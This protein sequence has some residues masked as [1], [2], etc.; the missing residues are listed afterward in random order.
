MQLE[1]SRTS[2][3]AFALVKVGVRALNF[4]KL[5]TM[6]PNPPAS[7]DGS[8]LPPRHRPSMGNLAKD[9]TEQDLWAFDDIDPMAEEITES[10]PKSIEQKIPVPR[11]TEKIKVRQLTDPTPS[12]SSSYQD[13]VRVN[14]GKS[15]TMAHVE[16]TSG[17]SKPGREFD[18]LDHWDEPNAAVPIL[19]IPAETVAPTA[20]AAVSPPPPELD[21]EFSP[22]VREQAAPVSLRP[23]MKL[24]KLERL[25]LVALCVLL[26]GGA[27]MA[28]LNTINRLPTDSGRVKAN[29]FPIRGSHI[30]IHSAVSFWRAPK[31]ADTARRGT[32]LVPVVDLTSSGGPAAIRVFFRNSDG[33]V[34]GDAVTRF[35]QAG[36]KL[37][38]A[39]TAGFDDVGM[40]AAYRTGG[41]KAWTI[42]VLE[43]ATENAPGPEFKRLFEMN[44][45]TDRR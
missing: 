45:S 35:L 23:R 11:E 32:Q 40:H 5:L 43:A 18:D 13:S 42:E 24:T 31:A 1:F 15:Q 29:D 19:Q 14:V 9:T 36:G 16:L 39:A 8:A 17:Q 44:I 6:T 30:T 10:P 7:P 21:D 26:L 3:S 25:G 28:F 4:R 20:P 27:A 34:I 2:D 37:Q 38:V 33:D 12:K 41:N 22:P